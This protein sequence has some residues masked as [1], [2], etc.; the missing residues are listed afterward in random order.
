MVDAVKSSTTN[1]I[2]EARIE[3]LVVLIAMS[4]TAVC[5]LRAI[6][7]PKRSDSWVKNHSSM[8]SV[9]V[10]RPVIKNDRYMIGTMEKIAK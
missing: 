10:M 8:E 3:S 1:P 5:K 9:A 6:S 7:E 4:V 2:T